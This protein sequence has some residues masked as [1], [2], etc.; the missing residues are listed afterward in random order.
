MSNFN[1]EA[2]VCELTGNEHNSREANKKKL[3]GVRIVRSVY[4]RLAHLSFTCF[5]FCHA[6]CILFTRLNCAGV[7]P[8]RFLK[9]VVKCDW[10]ANPAAAAIRSEE[11]R[12]G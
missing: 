10:L 3:N 7:I 2:A 9:A 4:C 11:R 12:V 6:R 1:S 8:V 5:A